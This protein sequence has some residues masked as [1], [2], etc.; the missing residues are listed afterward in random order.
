[1]KY[2]SKISSLKNPSGK[3]KKKLQQ[4]LD[5][6]PETREDYAMGAFGAQNCLERLEEKIMA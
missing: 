6:K 2:L 5:G 4:E 3:R 1:M